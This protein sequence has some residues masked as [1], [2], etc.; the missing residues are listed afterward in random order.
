[1][2]LE[3]CASLTEKQTQNKSIS[4]DDDTDRLDPH[5]NLSF[6]GSLES[7]NTVDRRSRPK[8]RSIRVESAYVKNTRFSRYQNAINASIPFRKITPRTEEI[9]VDSVGCLSN[10]TFSWARKYR[11][12]SIIIPQQTILPKSTRTDC[13]EINGKRLS[14]IYKYEHQSHGKKGSMFRVAWKFCSTRIIIASIIHLI[15]IV[16]GLAVCIFTK[17]C[18]ESLVEM[19]DMREIMFNNPVNTT[20]NPVDIESYQIALRNTILYSVG[21][22]SSLFLMYFFDS[23]SCWINLRT[24]NRLRTACIASTFSR[25]IKSSIIYKIAPHQ[26]LLLAAEEGKFIFDMVLKGAQFTSTFIGILLFLGASIILLGVPGMWPLLG[27]FGLFFGVLV[28][29]KMSSHFY[30]RSLQYLGLKM[31]QLDEGIKSYES[32]KILE[33]QPILRKMIATSISHQFN[34]L[35]KSELYTPKF[36]FGIWSSILLGGLYL[37]WCDTDIQTD[38]VPV[39]VL[40]VIYGHY[41]QILLMQCFEAIGCIFQGNASLDKIKN[42]YSI[43]HPHPSKSKPNRNLQVSI[44]HAI[45]E[46]TTDLLLQP[47]K[48]NSEMIKLN[49]CKKDLTVEDF[50]VPLNQI[51][52]ITGK[53]GSGKTSLLYSILGHVPIKTGQSYRRGKFAFFPKAPYVTNGSI[54]ANIIFGS[55]FDSIRY[56]KSISI[57]RLSNEICFTGNKDD[58]PIESFRFSKEQLERICFARAIFCDREIIV[59]D[60]PLSS[61]ADETEI[62]DIFKQ[63]TDNLLKAGKTVIVS[64]QNPSLLQH[65]QRIY[66]ADDNEITKC[67]EFEELQMTTEYDDITQDYYMNKCRQGIVNYTSEQED[68]EDEKTYMNDNNLR[69]NDLLS[70]LRRFLLVILHLLNST[71]YLLLP[72]GFVYTVSKEFIDP[73]LTYITLAVISFVFVTDIFIKNIVLKAGRHTLKQL[74]KRKLDIFLNSSIRAVRKLTYFELQKSFTSNNLTIFQNISSSIK[75]NISSILTGALLIAC[76]YWTVFGVVFTTVIFVIIYYRYRKTIIYYGK[77]EMKSKTD[78]L[79][80]VEN[81]LAGRAVIQSIDKVDTFRFEFYNDTEVNS[82]ALFIRTSVMCYAKFLMSSNTTLGMIMVI[83]ALL[84]GAPTKLCQYYFCLGMFLY[85]SY[86]YSLTSLLDVWFTTDY[87][88]ELFKCENPKQAVPKE[89]VSGSVHLQKE[90]IPVSIAFKDVT[91]NTNNE[92]VSQIKNFHLEKAEVAC[93]DGRSSKY[94]VPILMKELTPTVGTIF[95]NHFDIS[96]LSAWSLQ[97]NMGIVPK[98]PQVYGASIKTFLNINNSSLSNLSTVLQRFHIWQAV[99][100]LPNEL[101]EPVNN[102][103]QD[104]RQLLCLAKYWLMLK[105]ILVVENPHPDIIDVIDEVIPLY[106]SNS[107][108]IIVGSNSLLKCCKKFINLEE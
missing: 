24:A 101:D 57:S 13:C 3:D 103:N 51:I 68:E 29:S 26:H 54:R 38:T 45:F 33:S 94:I 5:V 104:Q 30:R 64:S 74:Q 21:I 70:Y 91:V 48:R 36:A 22:V 6:S 86:S 66:L 25:I 78:M 61:I 17:L 82:T 39:L 20:S 8:I 75:F 31:S 107:T 60:E 99:L 88:Q 55:D 62:A 105:P 10:A 85:L 98:N 35:F 90:D 16:C 34:N 100:H 65:C 92:M 28:L 93:I 79:M 72:I 42:I 67:L 43:T 71:A 53:S 47:L 95:V 27:I 77:L 96:T 56:Y 87:N 44:P 97:Q 102:L 73:W 11:V 50:F 15:S 23:T 80:R 37:I 18:L 106:F 4:S 63:A 58:Y 14:G 89:D 2:E 40:I 46:W 84:A 32:V 9:I 41:I 59:L 108:V 76:N 1:M 7:E 83:V 69:M 52:G 81:L 49:G 19:D 12:G